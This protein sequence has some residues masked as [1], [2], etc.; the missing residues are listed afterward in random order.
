MDALDFKQL[1]D[2]DR[3]Y[4]YNGSSNRKADNGIINYDFSNV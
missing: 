1:L 2:F 4:L 3:E